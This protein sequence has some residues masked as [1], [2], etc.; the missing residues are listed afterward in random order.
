M[1]SYELSTITFNKSP[2]TVGQ[3]SLFWGH[4]GERQGKKLC[5][6]QKT[7]GKAKQDSGSAGSV[8]MNRSSIKYKGC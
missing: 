4:E 6:Q 8:H 1:I 2:P 7:K 5:Q 3:A